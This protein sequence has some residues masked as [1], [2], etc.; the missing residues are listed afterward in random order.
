MPGTRTKGRP[1]QLRGM[2]KGIPD[3]KSAPGPGATAGHA[4]TW[5]APGESSGFAKS[6]FLLKI[7]TD[8]GSLTTE[9]L[10]KCWVI[11]FH[12]NSMAEETERFQ[13]GRDVQWPDDR[14]VTCAV[15]SGGLAVHG[16]QAF[17]GGYV[18]PGTRGRCP[19]RPRPPA[20]GDCDHTGNRSPADAVRMG[21]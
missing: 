12:R 14:A 17:L 20:V 19:P 21:M 6:V 4:Q 16:Q 8:R 2:P 1:T 11:S 9:S 10:P 18:R 15:I 13:R 5:G 7:F 3:T